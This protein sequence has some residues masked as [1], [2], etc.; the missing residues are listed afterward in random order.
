MKLHKI[1]D[2]ILF[3]FR[4][5][6][7]SPKYPASSPGTIAWLIGTEIKYGG[8]VNKVPRNKISPKDPR[9]KKQLLHGGMVGGD[10]MLL[11]FYSKMY[12][13]YLLPF[14]NR[15]N[16][17]TV[18]EFGIL[19][20]TGLAI[21]CDLFF[22]GRILGFDI[23]LEHITDNMDNLKGLGAFKKNQPEIYEYDQFLD[24]AEFLGSILKDDKI[25]ICI[26]D[27]FH[28]IES[29]LTT[30]KSVM[31]HLAEK[32]VYFIEDNKYVHKEI[33]STFPDLVIDNKGQFTVVTRNGR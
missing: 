5:Q 21:W 4:Q 11:N 22:N 30:M 29:I 7:Y 25:D 13:E 2:R 27:G 31:P 3:P 18:A 1:A 32:F 28:S 9:T 15:G 6:Y 19:K 20:G 24:N 14:V 23:D 10:R 17:V 16:P 8:M 12:S 26:D 33:K